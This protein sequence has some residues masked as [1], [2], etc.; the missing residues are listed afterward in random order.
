MPN[1][2]F[3][4][5]RCHN[6]Q[7]GPGCH[8]IIHS[9]GR[10]HVGFQHQETGGWLQVFE[11]G[12]FAATGQSPEDSRFTIDQTRD[13]AIS[14]KGHN[15]SWFLGISMFGHVE[16]IDSETYDRAHWKVEQVFS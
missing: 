10:D 4:Y 5:I 11:D 7:S 8:W 16:A 1:C 15:T 6:A 2:I 13:G 14:L 3:S 9:E 12:T